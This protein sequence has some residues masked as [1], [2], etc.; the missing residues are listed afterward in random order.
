MTRD[1]RVILYIEWKSKPCTDCGNLFPWYCMDHDHVPNRGEKLFEINKN[2]IRKPLEIVLTEIEKCDLVCSNC[3]RRR[4]HERK[5][6]GAHGI[7]FKN[8]CVYGHDLTDSRNQ[9]MLY[10]KRKGCLECRRVNVNAKY[11][12]EGHLAFEE[13]QEL[14]QARKRSKVK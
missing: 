3:H 1:E 4:T 12:N 7:T 10:G 11:H 9:Y 14:Y 8:T 6:P 13:K 5:Y 2:T